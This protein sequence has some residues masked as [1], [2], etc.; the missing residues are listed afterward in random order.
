MS[1]LSTPFASTASTTVI[2]AD[3]FSFAT[4]ACVS[5]PTCT[6]STAASKPSASME[7]VCG[8]SL[9]QADSKRPCLS[10]LM[11]SP[12]STVTAAPTISAPLASRT[13]PETR[14]K[15][16]AHC[17]ACAAVATTII[18][19]AIANRIVSALTCCIARLRLGGLCRQCVLSAT[20]G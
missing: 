7:N 19:A 6:C 10:V 3:G 2:T 17:C 1:S 5:A 9:T 14:T 18:I 4:S 8:P 15:C 11:S 16:T 20:W 12:A 13:S